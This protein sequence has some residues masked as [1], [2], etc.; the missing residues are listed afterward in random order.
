MTSVRSR[1]LLGA[2]VLAL[3]AVA[4]GCGGGSGDGTGGDGAKAGGSVSASTC[5]KVIGSGEFTIVSDLPLQG[6]SSHQTKQM[7]QAIQL[8]LEQHNWKAGAHTLQFQPC[9]DST[10]QLGSWDSATCS[11]NANAYAQTQSVVGIIGTFNSG[12]AQLIT[13]VANQ[14]PGGP[15]AMVS[16]ANTWP[17]LTQ[18]TAADP[19]E[20][21]KYYP[22]GT[23]NYARV[24]PADNFQG[25]ALAQLAQE[26]GVKSVYIINDKQAYG[27]GVA[28]YFESAAE[29]VGI[30]VLGNEGY[31]TK[32]GT[33]YQALFQKI[34]AKNPDAVMV[35]GLICENG[36][37]LIKDKVAVLGANSDVKLL[38]PDGFTTQ[39]TIDDAGAAAE[40]AYMSVGGVPVEQLSGAGATFITEFQK[41]YSPDAI[42]P[43]T[44]YAAAAAEVMLKAI[45]ASDG[46]RGDISAKLFGLQ[47]T[48]TVLGDFAIDPNGD[49]DQGSMT[50][51]I[52]KG[53]KLE[54]FK[55][56]EP[57]PSLVETL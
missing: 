55:V 57:D 46:S 26:L 32:T 45:E 14:A 1:V 22:S 8:V 54:T 31:N 7:N 9:D 41:K 49:T 36:G 6:S 40:G 53:G 18:K 44:P 5:G 35:G 52:A 10:A 13:P 2:A 42:D 23:R 28:N 16:P 12:C 48:G 56:I 24:I 21:D 15:I 39:S 27:L 25:P 43:Y 17:G 30:T 33:N 34:K 51:N 19:A 4:A 3:L 11:A 38:L 37:Q 29:K 47:M 50:I 20:P